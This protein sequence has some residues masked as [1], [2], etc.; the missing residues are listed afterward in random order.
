MWDRGE[1]GGRTK[2]NSNVAIGVN[3]CV[4]LFTSWSKYICRLETNI[5]RIKRSQQLLPPFKGEHLEWVWTSWMTPIFPKGNPQG[6]QMVSSKYP[7]HP[8]TPTVIGWIVDVLKLS[9]T[10]V[11]HLSSIQGCLTLGSGLRP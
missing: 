6:I 1:R 5:T 3:Y 2:E 9:A 11:T 4:A 10:K 7:V 8:H